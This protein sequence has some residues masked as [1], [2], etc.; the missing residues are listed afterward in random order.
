M[1]LFKYE[2]Y[3][4]VISEEAFALKV[5]R[6]I[7]NRDRTISKD[8]AIMEL[9]YIYFME[10]P[11]SDY[12]YIVDRD[13]RS[14][15]II[16]GE[17]LPSNWKP[18]KV[19]I[20]AMEFYSSF[21]PTSALLLEDTRYAVDKVRKLLRDID[22]EAEDGRGRPVYTIDKILAAIKQVPALVK[23]LD[24]AEKALASEMKQGGKMRG[25]GEKT[26]ME[27]SLDI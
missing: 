4:I 8:K 12:Q 16:E 21:K 23:D 18:D 5:F 19:I 26:I 3:K 13:E 1:K 17:G 15:A 22:L 27:D 6:Q 10:D 7:W 9:G 20:E 24:E 2:G 14:L 11:R 25:Q